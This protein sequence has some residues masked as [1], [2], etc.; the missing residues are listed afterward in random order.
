[1]SGV[2]T[3][4]MV[5]SNITGPGISDTNRVN[6]SQ[7]VLIGERNYEKTITFSYLTEADTGSYN[8]STFITSSYAYVIASDSTS[9]SE[10]ISVERK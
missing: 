3:N 5:Q 10:S 4:F 1:M 9:T 6:V 8:C 7:L 2:D